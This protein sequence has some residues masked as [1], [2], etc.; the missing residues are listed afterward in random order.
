MLDEE[1]DEIFKDSNYV[2][3]EPRKPKEKIIKPENKY[4][5]GKIYR[6]VDQF[7]NTVYIGSTTL[8]LNLRMNAHRCDMK[9]EISSTCKELKEK[10]GI[11]NITIELIEE[12]PCETKLQ[13]E[14]RE[15]FH[16]KNN[17]GIFNK[18]ESGRVG[19]HYKEYYEQN[20]ERIK[21]YYKKPEQK[22]KQKKRYQKNKEKIKQ[23]YREK[24]NK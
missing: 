24:H 6:L 1:F 2:N 12:Y 18:V 4:E 9:N 11:E 16:I 17:E 21:E 14:Q 19:L 5:C 10:I 23:K 13:L 7:N 22:E 20:K 15:N 8:T 3:G